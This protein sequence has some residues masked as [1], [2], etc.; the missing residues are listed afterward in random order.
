VKNSKLAVF[1]ICIFASW[2]IPLKAQ[3]IGDQFPGLA[4]LKAGSLPGPG[5][6]VT[7]PLY[8]R[9]SDVSIY[10]AHGNQV[11]K[12]FTAAI[13]VIAL[14]SVA[15]VTPF[16]ILGA[17]YGASYSQW[18]L[19]G[20]VNVAAANFHRSTSYG[21]GDIY[22]QP[23][24]LGWH[25]HAADITAGYAFFAPTGAGS[26][27]QHMWVNEIDF[28]GT[29]YLGEAKKW[30]VSTT[31]YYDFNRKKNN[32]DIKVGNI[33]TLAG[34]V[35]RSFLKGAAN[36]GVAYGAQWKMTHDS[37]SDI[38]P[39]LPITNGRFFALGPE[40]GVPV[41]AKG[42][43]VGLVSFRYLWVV[44]PKTALGGQLLV[45]SFTFAHLRPPK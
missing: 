22:A 12:N 40:V 42:L 8:Y 38:P 16:K 25:I 34:G 26:S 19:N 5:F 28:G 17:T 45:A 15:V 9:D 21:F 33:L 13:N 41:F 4:G 35:G 27:G 37:G 2:S 18:I 6:Y 39:F 31:S 30:N 11:L 7:L 43:N 3:Y 14:P 1:A 29:L 44:G 10:D 32:T 20:V 36:A 24:I 23:V